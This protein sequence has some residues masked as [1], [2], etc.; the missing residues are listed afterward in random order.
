[1]PPSPK[2]LNIN[3][4]IWAIEIAR[5]LDIEHQCR[6]NGHI[7]ITA[8]PPTT[9]TVIGNTLKSEVESVT[10]NGH[11]VQVSLPQGELP[12][13]TL[14]HSVL[15][16]NGDGTYNVVAVNQSGADIAFSDGK[17]V[18]LADHLKFDDTGHLLSG[19]TLNGAVLDKALDIKIG[20]HQVLGP[21]DPH[22]TSDLQSGKEVF[23]NNG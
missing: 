18:V 3:S 13:H 9:E 4:S 5:Q 2:I 1:M 23:G 10:V 8:G 12:D 6:G 7:G 14:W 17:P 20:E 11:Q 21:P 19:K 15:R 22:W 16:P